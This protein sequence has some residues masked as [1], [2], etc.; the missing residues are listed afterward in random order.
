MTEQ[1]EAEIHHLSNHS[2]RDA[3]CIVELLELPSYGAT[4]CFRLTFFIDCIIVL[5]WGVTQL[6]PLVLVSSKQTRN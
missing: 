1:K 6:S 3:P 2:N 4:S 5:V